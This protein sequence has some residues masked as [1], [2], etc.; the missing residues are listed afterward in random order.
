MGCRL[1]IAIS[2]MAVGG[3]LSTGSRAQWC[4]YFSGGPTDC[5]FSNL[6]QCIEAIRGKAGLCDRHPQYEPPHATTP[7]KR[8][9]RSRY[10]KESA[11]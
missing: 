7:V 3:A 8:R 1:A 5:R 9:R 6:E 10:H 2:V 4:A 11:V